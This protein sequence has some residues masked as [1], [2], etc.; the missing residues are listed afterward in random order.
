MRVLKIELKDMSY[1]ICIEKNV[2]DS[3][4]EH[5]F[6]CY[7]CK[8]VAIITDRNI[9]KLYGEKINKILEEKGFD[10]KIVSVSPGEKSKS[11][12]VLKAV[13]NELSQ[14]NIGREDLII[15]FGGGIIG[16]LGGFAASTYLRGIP[17]IQIPTSLLAQVDSSIGGKVAVNL[18]NGKNL[19]GSFYHPR[20]VLIDPGLL[21]TM[22]KNYFCDGLAEV[23]KYGFI[24]DKHIIYEL[25]KYENIDKLLNNIDSIIFKCCNIKKILV[26]KDEKDFEERM[27]LNF[28]HTIGHAIEKYYNYEGYTHGQAVAIGMAEITR[29]SEECHITNEGTLRVLEEVLKKY[30]LP[31]K[32]PQMDKGYIFKSITL[33][34]KVSG[35]NISLVVLRDIGEGIIKKVSI[36]KVKKYISVI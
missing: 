17:Y 11:I 25:M 15:A 30:D 10:V 35:E 20:E 13:Y 12:D 26:E 5:I 9:K 33:D 21:K 8:K 1:S 14:F 28:G 24:K 22:E 7:N 31:Y 2:L 18:P 36:D 4:G 32:A 6:E 3:I 34:K 29:I 19:I 23:I 27:L 16:D